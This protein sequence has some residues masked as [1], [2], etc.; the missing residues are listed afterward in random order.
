MS[1]GTNDNMALMGAVTSSASGMAAAAA[2]Q[3]Q[4]WQLQQRCSSH[5]NISDNGK[6]AQ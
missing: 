5:S 6:Q 2:P 4:L 3:Q 1:M